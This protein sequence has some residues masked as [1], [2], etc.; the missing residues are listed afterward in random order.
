MHVNIFVDTLWRR[1]KIKI[2]IQKKCRLEI[3]RITPNE[4]KLT[5]NLCNTN[6]FLFPNYRNLI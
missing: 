2:D 6:K 1:L 3:K 4:G 5:L